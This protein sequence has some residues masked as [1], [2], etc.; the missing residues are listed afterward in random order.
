MREPPPAW[1]LEDFLER[2]E[3]WV[4]LEDPSTDL[5]L[6]VLPWIWTRAETPHDG[7]DEVAGIEDLWFGAVPNTEDNLGH[8][9]TCAYWIEASRR[10]VRCDSFATLD[11]P[12]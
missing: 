5:R 9:V 1:R 12:L 4:E 7:V 10:V 2:F 8:V 11:L 3:A 6:L